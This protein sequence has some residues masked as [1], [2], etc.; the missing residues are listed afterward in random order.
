MADELNA[1]GSED[2]TAPVGTVEG[3]R[4][5]ARK[6]NE[7]FSVYEK[8][9]KGAEAQWML[10]LRQF[11]GKWDIAIAE[12]IPAG[13][14]HAYPKITRVK[15][16]ALVAR[17]MSLL[18]PAGEKNWA[19]EASRMPNLPVETLQA[20]LEKWQ[21][22]NQGA[23]PT[24]SVLDSL[25][26]H[27]AKDMAALMER[28][29][30]DQLEDVDPYATTSYQQLVRKVVHSAV[31]YGPGVI[32]G[33][34]TIKDTITKYELDAGGMAQIVELDG[35]RPYME[36]VPCWQYYP[37]M[38][39][40]NFEQMSGEFQRHSYSRA[41][42]ARLAT[43]A[44]FD[45]DAI[46]KYLEQH[47]EGDDTKPTYQTELDALGGQNV[48]TTQGQKGKFRVLEFWGT[49]PG[50]ALQ[51]AGV[52]EID[53]ADL[54]LEVR[55]TAWVLGDQLIKVSKNPY[56]EGTKTF[57][58]FIFEEDEVNLLGSG[59]PPIMRDSQLGVSTFTRM[60]V[61]NASVVCGPNLE[62]DLEVLSPSQ[63]DY[64]IRS[65][66]AWLKEGG[67][68]G[69][70]AVQSVSFDSHIPELRETIDLFL[71]FADAE[72][73][74]SPMTGGDL[75]NVPGEA[76]RTTGGASMVYA[77]AALP[78]RDIVRNFD[79]FTVSVI[80]SLVQWNTIFNDRR[81]E[82]AG[83][84]RPVAKGAT[85][86]MAKEVRSYALDQLAQT[87]TPEDS[88]YIDR[89][90]LL[91]ERLSVRDLPR[92]VLMVDDEEL[93]R[94][95]DAA[96][97]EAQA[98]QQQQMQQFGAMLEQMR[99]D[100]LKSASQ[101]QKNLDTGEAKVFDSLVKAIEAGRPLDE[102]AAIANRAGA[103]RQPATQQLPA[104]AA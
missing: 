48:N 101:A 51:A 55:F 20:E 61:D 14:S 21:A 40:Q 59:L 102:L 57:H 34:L 62:I 37:E 103:S 39:A 7:L 60:L 85:S 90:E 1:V 26:S 28:F 44:D 66:K 46:R 81:D 43:R 35:F 91:N 95:Q 70:R 76:M 88:M 32:K 80:H 92:D 54:D 22:A 53:E 49:M 3:R 98:A 72:T 11:L 13:A 24:Q 99:A 47:Q 58:Q 12:A 27:A 89:K 75:E 5:L 42:A 4:A 23:A 29:I 65:F 36:W 71:K 78:F 74:V 93:K 15:V 67:T 104:T 96:A 87:L 31:L 50:R 25:V 17:L 63:T 45:G 100:T 6:L 38:S 68:S 56:P 52:R 30:D 41:H 18:F 83:D 8:E 16:M 10:N 84:T 79:R 69:Q 33:P 77:N 64:S 97:Q 19:L 2:G 86:L 82:L 73:F 9:R 94:R